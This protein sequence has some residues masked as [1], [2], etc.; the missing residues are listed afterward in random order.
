[1]DLSRILQ[2][3]EESILVVKIGEHG[4]LEV[5]IGFLS[6]C[7]NYFNVFY[8]R[9]ETS[10]FVVYNLKSALRLVDVSNEENPDFRVKL[11]ERRGDIDIKY[12]QY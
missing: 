6:P 5:V 10:L 2:S 1:M 8:L 7:L 4:G 9:S 3:V 12:R 11:N